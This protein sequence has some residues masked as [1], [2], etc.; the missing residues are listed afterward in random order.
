MD[1]NVWADA[2]SKVGPRTHRI[3]PA[4]GSGRHG[5]LGTLKRTKGVPGYKRNH[6][7]LLKSMEDSGTQR[8][9]NG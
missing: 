2:A 8:F 9:A 7:K 6:G 4:T 5:S 1:V 3:S